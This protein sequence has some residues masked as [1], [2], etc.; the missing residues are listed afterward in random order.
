ML[1]I[2]WLNFIVASR[3]GKQPWTGYD[4][5]EGGVANDRVIDTIEDYLNDIITIEQ[6]L[7]QLVYAQPNHQICLLNQ[8]LIDTHLHFDK[9]F[10]LDT[11]D[12]K[13]GN[14]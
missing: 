12:R 11:M 8:Q 3:N 7:G 6:A 2:D 1:T 14:K 4:I 5:I 13:G 10:P 9:S